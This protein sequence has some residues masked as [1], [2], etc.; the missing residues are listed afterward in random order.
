MSGA[1]DDTAAGH[2]QTT[3]LPVGVTI[4]IPIF[5]II[6][7]IN[8]LLENIEL[9]SSRSIPASVPGLLGGNGW[10]RPSRNFGGFRQMR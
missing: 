1:I 7:K 3:M 6:I 8:I 10:W 2:Y 5:Y 9:E 4:R